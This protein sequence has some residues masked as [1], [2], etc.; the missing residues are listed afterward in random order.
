MLNFLQ[1]TQKKLEGILNDK[2]FMSITKQNISKKENNLIQI[3]SKLTLWRKD[4]KDDLKDYCKNF[5][6][7]YGDEFVVINLTN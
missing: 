3:I 5:T 6:N 2:N 7:K 1:K 4:E